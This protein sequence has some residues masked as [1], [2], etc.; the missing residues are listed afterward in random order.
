MKT[1][2]MVFF[3]LEA[4]GTDVKTDRITQIGIVLVTKEGRTEWETLVNPGIPISP[5]ASEVTGITDEMVAS[6]PPFSKVANKVLEIFSDYPLVG[7]NSN[8]FDIPMLAHEFNRIGM[9]WTPTNKFID[10]GTM[11]MRLNP[12]TLSAAYAEYVGGEFEAHNA[13]ADVK[14]TIDVF[15]AML[16]ANEEIPKKVSELE[17][18]SNYDCKRADI[19]GCFVY[20][21]DELLLN[22]GKHKGQPAKDH[23]DF[24]M[25]MYSKDFLPDTINIVHQILNER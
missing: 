20:K 13:L 9:A 24:L 12:R 1:S 21:D 11:Y 25:W 6:A 22:F 15:Q 8:R 18:Y 4:T 3:D 16:K 19:S 2:L 10:I 5:G 14:A 7:F 17:L 23:T